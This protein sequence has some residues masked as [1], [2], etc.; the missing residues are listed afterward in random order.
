MRGHCKVRLLPDC[1]RH[2]PLTVALALCEQKG[3]RLKGGLGCRRQSACTSRGGGEGRPQASHRRRLPPPHLACTTGRTCPRACCPPSSPWRPAL[4]QCW[5]TRASQQL[6]CPQQAQAWPPAHLER[7]HRARAD[8]AAVEVGE[9]ARVHVV[10]PHPLQGRALVGDEGGGQG[11]LLL[12]LAGRVWGGCLGGALAAG[13]AGSRG[14]GGGGGGAAAASDPE[15]APPDIPAARRSVCVECGRHVGWGAEV[16]SM[17][18]CST[19][20]ASSTCCR[21]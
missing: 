21:L 7:L 15:A 16:S 17:P 20:T 3:G 8:Q 11:L 5:V 10:P 1:G 19:R 12:G 18:R 4:S 14:G 13:G 2:L 9:A 6:P